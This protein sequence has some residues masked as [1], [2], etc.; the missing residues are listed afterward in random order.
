MTFDDIVDEV[1]LLR[2]KDGLRTQVQR[3]VNERYSWVWS[4]SEWPFKY[5]APTNLTVTSA[6]NT[7]T[8][9]SDFGRV[10]ALYNDSGARL[11]YRTPPEFWELYTPVAT[12]APPIDYT[13]QDGVLY[14]GPTPGASATYQIAYERTLSHKNVSGTVVAG[15]MSADSDTPIW[16]SRHHY[17]L[18]MGALS[19]GMKAMN[20]PTWQSLETEFSNLFTV[21]QNDLLPPD[22]TE[23]VQWGRDMLGYEAWVA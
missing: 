12:S 7:P 1:I 20:D 14:L 6:D 22:R 9:P 11:T 21:M 8:L 5:A 15:L 4:A 10:M 3:W 17:I 19:T 2:F 23:S 18:V 13:V 16:D